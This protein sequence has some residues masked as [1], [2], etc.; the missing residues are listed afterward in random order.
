[1]SE[2]IERPQ[3]TPDAATG[4][5]WAAAHEGRLV[6]PRCDDCGKYHFYPHPLCPF[7]SSAKL[8]WTPVSGR[9]S[10][11]SFCRASR[12]EQGVCRGGALCG[13]SGAARRR[14]AADEQFA[15]L[16]AGCGADRHAAESGVSQALGVGYT[17]R[18]RAAIIL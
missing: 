4:P 3:P 6:M 14:S 8:V 15:G 13:G 18:V 11:Y 10:L 2:V 9:A 12:T 17:A 5:Y 1:M 16:C 7:C